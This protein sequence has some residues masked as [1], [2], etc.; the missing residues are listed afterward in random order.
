MNRARNFAKLNGV[1]E[2]TFEYIIAGGGMAGLSLA[3]Y[4]NENAH[5]RAKKVLIIDR[6]A[7][8]ENDHTWCFWEKQKSAFEEIIFRKWKNIRFHG[9]RGFSA[10]LNLGDYEYKMIRAADFYKFVFDK[11]NQNPNFKFLQN[12]II[13][14][15]NGSVKTNDGEFFADEFIFDSFTRKTYDNPKYQNLFQ[16]FHGWLIET[17]SNIFNRREPTL[18]DFRVEQKNECRFIYILPFSASHALVEFT[19]FSD[20][21]LK[22]S[23]YEN[24]LKKYLAGILK[25]ENYKILETE[26]GVIPMSDEPHEQFP[27]KKVIR[28]GTSGG[29]VKPSTGYSF[30]RTQ[31]N[32]QKLVGFLENA[33]TKNQKPKTKNRSWKLFLDSVLLNVLSTKK[34]AADDVFTA[35]FSKNPA[36]KV[37]KFLDEETSVKEDFA[38]MK[39][40][41]LT[42]FTKAAIETALKKFK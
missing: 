4:L 8:I 16:H 25:I 36:D 26:T 37:L 32:L 27:E 21:I 42:P 24:N 31:K 2:N 13:S 7:K 39:T 22:K 35:L 28:I 14:V 18:F 29:Y 41:P 38:I 19:V 33:K 40:V 3:F 15:E 20:N 17:E 34:H 30:R 6:D 5:L 11:I 12:E 10:S 9:T 1:T 23:E